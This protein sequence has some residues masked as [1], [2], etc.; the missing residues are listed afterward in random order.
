MPPGLTTRIVVVP[1]PPP[2]RKM[3]LGRL[4]WVALA[5]GVERCSDGHGAVALD[6]D[7]RG[8]ERRDAE[9]CCLPV[10]R[11]KDGRLAQ[12]GQCAVK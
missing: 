5:L 9:P 8:V 2:S 6:R 3:C 7:V 4:P 1:S 10:R 12:R 11:R